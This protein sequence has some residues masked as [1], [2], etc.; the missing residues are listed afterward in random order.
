LSRR[1]GPGDG[2]GHSYSQP[3]NGDTVK[4]VIAPDSFKGCLSATEVSKAIEAGIFAADPKSE[5]EKIPLADGGEGTA[6]ALVHA[7]GGRF[8]SAG[9]EG[10]LGD[11][12]EAQFGI[13]GDE[14]TAVI[15]MAAASG[16]P[17][18]PQEQRDPARTTTYGTGQLIQAALDAGCHRLVVGIGG[19][20]TTDGG[21]GMAQA[22]GARMLDSQ[23]REISRA[24]GG[25]LRNIAE[26]DTSDIDP[27]IGKCTMRVAC[28]VDNPLLGPRGAAVV[29]GPQKGATPAQIEKLEAGLAHFAK[30]VERDLGKSVTDVPRAGAAGGLGAGLLAFCD[31][32]LEPGIDIILDVV[33]LAEKAA[34][35]ELIITGE[36]KI[37][38]QTASGKAPMGALRI[39]QQLG[40]PV[41]A[42]SGS[43]SPDASQL[44]EH[45]FVALF[46]CLREPMSLAEAMCPQTARQMLTATAQQIMRLWLAT[47]RKQAIQQ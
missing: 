42:I 12:I 23:G 6:D 35:A 13:L 37:D 14:E 19:S 24:S 25:Q 33:R 30:L 15:E 16:L 10:P 46:S 2:C 7:T 47:N 22:L 29:Y 39:G 21:A 34:G 26:I 4:I 44:N 11:S 1:S 9:V 20:A 45:G 41:I 38:S 32:Q 18:I 5:C 8:V 36:G 28:D 3:V 31:A 27:R 40:V 17:L 43:I